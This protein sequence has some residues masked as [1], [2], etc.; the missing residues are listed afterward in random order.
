[1]VNLCRHGNTHD[2]NHVT[3]VSN[4]YGIIVVTQKVTSEITGNTSCT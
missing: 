1:M 4:G 3:M 2:T